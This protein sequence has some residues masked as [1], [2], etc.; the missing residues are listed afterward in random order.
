MRLPRLLAIFLTAALT[1]F[2][3]E[4]LEARDFPVPIA[5]G[6]PLLTDGVADVAYH[7]YTFVDGPLDVF[8]VRQRTSVSAR[9]ADVVALGAHWGTYLMVGPVSDA[10]AA[11]SIARWVMH[12][13][14]FEYEVR[15]ATHLGPV[16]LVARYGRTSQHPLSSAGISE[17]SSDILEVE[18]S[19]YR[20][21]ISSGVRLAYIDLYDFWQSPLSAPRTLLRLEV[22]VELEFPFRGFTLVARTWPRILVLRQTDAWSYADIDPP[23]Q[24]EIDA[25]LGVRVGSARSYAEFLLEVYTTQ[26]SEQRRGEPSPLTTVGLTARIGVR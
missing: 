15:A 22:P 5:M 25:E 24:M 14:Q 2:S 1:A 19:T 9:P 8:S 26:D 21:T 17:V 23:V 16:D 7:D 10:G 12:A 4:Y 11:F 18:V 20:R 13:V 3:T 6:N